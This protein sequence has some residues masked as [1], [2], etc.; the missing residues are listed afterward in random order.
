M[1]EII[2]TT[3]CNLCE[4]SQLVINGSQG[5]Y[6]RYLCKKCGHVFREEMKFKMNLEKIDYLIII[7]LV[8]CI[9]VCGFN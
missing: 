4:S 9:L 3:K 5:G 7:F 6:D 1:L 8:S 2:M